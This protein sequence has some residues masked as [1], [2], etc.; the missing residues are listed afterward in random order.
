MVPRP[1]RALA[2]LAA[3]LLLPAS[4]HAAG[5]VVG[6]SASPSPA[7]TGQAVT[8]TILGSGGCEFSVVYGRGEPSEHRAA[9]QLPYTFTKAFR[10]AGIYLVTVKPREPSANPCQGDATIALTVDPPTSA[11][12]APPGSR[13]GDNPCP[14]GWHPRG[15]VGTYK[16]SKTFLCA[17]DRPPRIQC[18]PSTVYV[19]TNFGFGC[20][21]VPQ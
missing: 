5:S 3:A 1:A 11:Q 17:P 16:G 15:A 20:Q 4:A 21:A 12:T 14:S 18:G 7:V 10:A 9:A 8:F 19:E 13:R 2:A 6:I